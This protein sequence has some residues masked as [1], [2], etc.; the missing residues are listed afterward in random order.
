M[1]ERRARRDGHARRVNNLLVLTVLAAALPAAEA[2]IIAGVGFQAARGLP[3]QASAV[4][5]YD[6]YHDLRWLLVYH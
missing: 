6:S 3:S 1:T 4:W 2:A 5:P